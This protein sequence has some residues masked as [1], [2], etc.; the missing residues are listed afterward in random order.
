M[1]RP[2]RVV[3]WL[4]L[5]ALVATIH[6]QWKSCRRSSRSMLLKDWRSVFN[7]VAKFLGMEEWAT[8]RA[9]TLVHA[10]LQFALVAICRHRELQS[11]HRQRTVRLVSPPRCHLQ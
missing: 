2:E 1:C 8:L 3:C 7:A 4:M 9:F 6:S 10:K 11:T 5:A